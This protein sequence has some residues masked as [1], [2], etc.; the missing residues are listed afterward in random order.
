MK[1]IGDF[2]SAFRTFACPV[3]GFLYSKQAFYVHLIEFFARFGGPLHRNLNE[4][5]EYFASIILSASNG[6][7]ANTISSTNLPL[8]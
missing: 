7:L 6:D 5:P 1:M 8:R 2:C 4:P 3:S